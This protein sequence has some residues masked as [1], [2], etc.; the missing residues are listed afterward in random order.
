MGLSIRPATPNDAPQWLELIRA[1][2]GDNYPATEVYDLDWIGAQ[3]DPANGPETWVAEDAGAIKG[4][5]SFLRGES[6]NPNPVCNVGRNVFRPESFADGSALTLLRAVTDVTNDRK[7]MAVI[8]VAAAENGQQIA[9]EKLGYAC[10]GFQPLKHMM[11]QRVGVLF[12]VH[13]AKS[14]LATRLPMSES[15]PQVSELGIHSLES[16]QIGNSMTVRD[17]ASGYP[18]QCELTV[19]DGTHDDFELW[20]VQAEAANPPVE[21]SG[22]FNFGFGL[23]RLPFN[24]PLRAIL[25]QRDEKMVAGIA[26]YFDE[27]DKCVRITDGFCAD[28]LSIGALLAAA[29]KAAQEQFNAVYTEIDILATAPRLLK[30]AEQL[31][32]VPVAYLPAFFS[33]GSGNFDVVKMVKL[34]LPYSIE[35]NEFTA[36]ARATV[37]IIDRSFQDQK[38]GLGIINL[39]RPLSMFHGLGDG[40]LRKIARLF[41]QKL[42]RGGD[43]VFPKGASGEEAYVILRGKINIHLDTAAPPI[44]QLVEGKIFGE[45]AFLDGA[46]RVANAVAAQPSILLVMQRSAFNDLVR[47]EPN[48]GMSVMRNLALDLAIKLRGVN[49]ALSGAG[50]KR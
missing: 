5:I 8:R 33:G 18:L 10:V 37:E 45:L 23:F 39:L 42:Y 36:H 31:G 34:N 4:S 6:T 11:R 27:H 7:Q 1:S 22:R 12:Y 30:S 13:G 35:S 3:L 15:L 41:V 17:G 21:I 19:H 26:Y 16:L 47:R 43:V 9:L 24:A 2:F 50:R 44:A 25:G 32:F 38:L 40:E 48:L 29:V 14:A 49:D 46:P 20:R 28:D